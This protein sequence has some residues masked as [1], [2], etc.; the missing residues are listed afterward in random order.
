[1]T[2]HGLTGSV[3]NERSSLSHRWY[4]QPILRGS[5]HA[6]FCTVQAMLSMGMGYIIRHIILPRNKRCIDIP[7]FYGIFAALH[8]NIIPMIIV[9]STY[10]FSPFILNARHS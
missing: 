10:E 8:A 3:G 5:H 4:R 1:M 2:V 6:V 7:W 9:V